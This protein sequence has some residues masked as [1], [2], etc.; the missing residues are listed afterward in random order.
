MRLYK[1]YVERAGSRIEVFR[2]VRREFRSKRVLY[3][4][5]YVH[6]TPSLIFPEVIFVDSDIRAKRFFSCREEIWDHINQ[7]KENE[8]EHLFQFISGDYQSE[9]NIPLNSIDLLISEY[10]GFVSIHTKEYLRN[11]GILLA[12]DSHGDA[13]LANSDPDFLFLGVLKECEGQYCFQKGENERY[14]RRY[15][16]MAVDL[17]TVKNTM[18]GPK[19]SKSADYY[20]FQ[21]QGRTNEK[22]KIN[23][24]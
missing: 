13:T 24:K 7:F 22:E 5:S 16:N 9:M 21:K 3:P 18:K 10:A 17:D 11:G 20:I 23:Q 6:L 1:E 12:G 15:R 19:Y 8:E 4:G 14:F 2:E